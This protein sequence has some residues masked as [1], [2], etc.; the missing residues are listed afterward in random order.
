MVERNLVN[1]VVEETRVIV[2]KAVVDAPAW[3]L[4]EAPRIPCLSRV[5]P[6][7]TYMEILQ[8]R[9]PLT[10]YTIY[11]PDPH[12]G[13]VMTCTLYF[14]LGYF[15]APPPIEALIKV[16]NTPD[17]SVYYTNPFPA[18]EQTIIATGPFIKQVQVVSE[19]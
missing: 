11:E 6:G 3:V 19:G 7:D 9:E 15:L 2:G 14:E 12:R 5:L 13:P 4:V 10:P 17:G 1:I 8:V 16:V 18:S